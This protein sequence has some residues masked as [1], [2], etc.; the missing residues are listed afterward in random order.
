TCPTRT[1]HLPSTLVNGQRALVKLQD[2]QVH[3]GGVD[4]ADAEA[5]AAGPAAVGVLRRPQLL[6][7]GLAVLAPGQALARRRRP[8][9][10][11]PAVVAQDVQRLGVIVVGV[12]VVS[13]ADAA[14]DGDGRLA[15]LEP[16]LAEVVLV[17]AGAEQAG[18][19]RRRQGRALA[20]D[21]RPRAAA[22]EAVD[23][24]AAVGRGVLQVVVRL[25]DDGLG[26]GDAG[27]AR[28]PQRLR[29]R[30]RH[31]PLVLVV[32]VLGGGVEPAALGGLGVADVLDGPG[33][34][35]LELGPAVLVVLV[36]VDAGQKER[37]EAVAVH[38]AA[39]L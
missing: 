1:G 23:D 14:L 10:L 8:E 37:G 20:A 32:A 2:G 35:V 3:R 12:L 22:A 15:E 34:D 25:L 21:R 6:E 26:D 17:L 31:R 38:V 5:A 24:A 11:L 16:L 30:D 33:E 28:R 18:D 7:H 13:Q 4:G 19:G 29:L 27:V 39:G 36:A 9:H